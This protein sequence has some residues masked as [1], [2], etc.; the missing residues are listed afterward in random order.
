MPRGRKGKKRPADVNG[1]PG[2]ERG[3][4]RRV[5]A[6]SLAF[7]LLSSQISFAASKDDIDRLATFL[8]MLGR[9]IACGLP[10]SIGTEVFTWFVKK[11]PPGSR[12]QKLYGQV[13]LEGITINTEMQAKGLSPDTCDAV[14]KFFAYEDVR[15]LLRD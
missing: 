4:K 11:F 15:Q 10:K 13:F 5:I 9:A 8:V 7:V 3:R 1:K 12:D 6:S 2:L 14:A